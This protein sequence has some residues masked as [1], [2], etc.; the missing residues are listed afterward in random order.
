MLSVISLDFGGTLA[1]E[2]KEEYYAFHEIL[3]EL[4]YAVEV[5]EV[6]EALS[7]AW[8]LWLQEKAETGKV[9]SEEALK[10]VI[11]RILRQVGAPASDELVLRA[12]ELYPHKLEFKAYPDAEPTL[13]KLKQKEK[14]KLIVISNASSQRNVEIYLENLGLKH[15]FDL[16]IVS[17]T[18]GYEKPDPK[19]FHAAAEMLDVKP[20]E[21]LHVGDDYEADYLGAISAGLK[22]VLIDRKDV[23]KGKQCTRIKELTELIGLLNELK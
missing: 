7:I 1:C 6:R 5:E 9:W 16:I 2:V 12:A 17:G 19:I 22:G 15:Y 3:R 4:G 21:M 18:I 20:E 10:G 11:R 8:N 13:K 23:H 14:Y